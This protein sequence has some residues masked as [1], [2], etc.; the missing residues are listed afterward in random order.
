[1]GTME[2]DDD[3]TANLVALPRQTRRLVD[4]S[5]SISEIDTE[6]P[7]YLH[8]LLCQLG[9]PRSRQEDRKF[10][11]ASGKVSMMLEAGSI[12]TGRG[13]WKELPLPYGTHPRLVLYHLCSEADH[14]QSNMIDVGGSQRAY[15]CRTTPPGRAG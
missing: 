14:P 9:L 6:R 10:Y 5:L 12:A 2:N 1:M 15:L 7:E 3:L 8:A 11:R 4:A 13:Q